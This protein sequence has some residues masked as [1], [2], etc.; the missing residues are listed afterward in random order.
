[1]TVPPE[2]NPVER[3]WQHLRGRWLSHR[4]LAGGSAAVLEAACA[5]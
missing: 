4:V 5:A 2:L 3:I 1:L